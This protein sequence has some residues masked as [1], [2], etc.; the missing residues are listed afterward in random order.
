MKQ[1]PRNSL[2]P[3]VVLVSSLFLT[4]PAMAT[5]EGAS[6]S[7]NR[8]PSSILQEVSPELMRSFLHLQ[9][10]IHAT[11]LAVER[12]RMES[13]AAA[14]RNAEAVNARLKFIEDV[15]ERVSKENTAAIVESN[16]QIEE[17]NRQL[18]KSNSRMVLLASVF[19]FILLAG[20]GVTGWM[21]WK[22]VSRVGSYP[23]TGLPALLSQGYSTFGSGGQ[24]A[25][26]ASAQLMSVLGRLEHRIAEMESSSHAS[27]PLKVVPVSE[28]VTEHPHA[29]DE[30]TFDSGSDIETPLAD[31]IRK[32]DELLAGE[33]AEKAIEHF[34][35]LLAKHPGNPEL[36][37]RRGTALERLQRDQEAIECYDLAIKA[38]PHL[39]M[40]YLHKGGLFNRMERF[41]EAME[42]YEQALRVQ[43][44]RRSA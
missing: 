8:A 34:D 21:Q 23:G 4:R 29:S 27:R 44:H 19:A 41:S 39:T 36:L 16:R 12:S 33:D 20:L 9:E 18:Q 5:E 42:C 7:T 6:P 37:L 3:A 40:A 24:P 43:E 32:G 31:V 11:Q 35:A 15:M 17:S 13:E 26:L 14:A 2:V 25:Q 22:A 28:A 38:D 30:D 10:Q 1:L